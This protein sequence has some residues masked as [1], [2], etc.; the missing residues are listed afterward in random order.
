MTQVFVSLTIE[1]VDEEST[2]AR[3]GSVG[4]W[5][6]PRTLVLAQAEPLGQ[7]VGGLDC[8]GGDLGG[9]TAR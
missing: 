5:R 3:R 2:Y 4:D 8:V 9:V 1:N 7:C 6:Y